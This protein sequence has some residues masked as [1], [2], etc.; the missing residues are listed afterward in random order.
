MDSGKNSPPSGGTDGPGQ[1]MVFNLALGDVALPREETKVTGKVKPKSVSE[2]VD[3]LP[4]FDLESAFAEIAEE[5]ART[6]EQPDEFFE[7]DELD[8][9]EKAKKLS[10]RQ[11]LVL[12]L[13]MTGLKKGEAAHRA[14]YTGAYLSVLLRTP[15]AQAYLEYLSGR[16][17]QQVDAVQMLFQENS[18]KA[19]IRVIDIMNDPKTNRNLAATCA[20]DI[21]DR[22]GHKPV[23]KAA[24]VVNADVIGADD[25]KRIAA[26]NDMLKEIYNG[27]DV[28]ERKGS[29]PDGG[30]Q[31]P[32][33]LRSG[34]LP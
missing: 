22:A 5:L 33:P 32:D 20:F 2:V 16:M 18:L 10:G 28:E 31:E 4:G 11:R 14:G 29:V 7:A 30:G 13:V 24:V 3:E 17:D 34:L 25:I 19:A 1:E 12:R 23:Q 9:P 15:E 21:L 6:E 27:P 26:A 8:I